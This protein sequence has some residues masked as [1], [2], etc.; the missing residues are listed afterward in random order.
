MARFTKEEKLA[1]ETMAVQGAWNEFR[2]NYQERFVALMYEY[3]TLQY[4]NEGFSVK[5]LG[6]NSY[7]FKG[8][9]HYNVEHAL[10]ATLPEEP[11]R[12]YV[13]DFE[14]VEGMAQTYREREAEALRQ[15]NVKREAMAKVRATLSAEE[16]QLLGL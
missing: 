7:L 13:W 3:M 8:E 2:A 5:K 10:M 6:E 14:Q 12:N 15:A 9:V 11:V 16:L 4:Q 1:M